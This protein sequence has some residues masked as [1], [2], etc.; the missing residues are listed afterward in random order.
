MYQTSWVCVCILYCVGYATPKPRRHIILPYLSVRLYHSFAHYLKNS[1]ILG[2]QWKHKVC[3][4]LLYNLFWNTSSTFNDAFSLMYRGLHDKFGYF[5]SFSL[6][7]RG[8]HD[9]FGYFVSFS[10]LYRGLHDK[11]G[12]F[13]SFS[14]KSNFVHWCSKKLQ[15][16]KAMNDQ[17]VLTGSFWRTD[18]LDETNIRL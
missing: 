10:L 15:K 1:T 11:F 13:V 3:F 8:L 16:P 6:L 2:K 7:Y 14:S 17:P 12:Y 5:V 9:K 18:R 4:D